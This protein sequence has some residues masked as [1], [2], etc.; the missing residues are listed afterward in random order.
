M[1][2]NFDVLFHADFWAEDAGVF[3]QQALSSPGWSN[4]FEPYAG[5]LHFIPRL[6]A[7]VARALPLLWVPTFLNGSAL[8]FQSL[9]AAL[10]L[11][12]RHAFFRERSSQKVAAL[13]FVLLPASEEVMGSIT[14][15]N[16]FVPF[17]L[18]PLLFAPPCRKNFHRAVDWV[19]F[20]AL[21]L[22]GPWSLFFF[23]LYVLAL[24]RWREW[25]DRGKLA[26]LGL[27]FAAQ[28]AF[29]LQSSRIH[30]G[31]FPCSISGIFR[32]LGQKTFFFTLFGQAGAD[33]FPWD[34]PA[35]RSAAF[36]AGLGLLLLLFLSA[37]RDGKS[38]VTFLISVF[39]LS[40]LSLA[41][42]SNAA[43]TLNVQNGNRYF[44]LG[45]FLTML[46]LAQHFLRS[47]PGLRFAL[48]AG[49]L[50]LSALCAVPLDFANPRQSRYPMP[51]WP[52]RLESL[53]D[54]AAPGTVVTLPIR[55]NGAWS[56]RLVKP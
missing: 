51:S 53:Y 50:A 13:L 27:A 55:P 44:Y 20:I 18:T 10:M 3:F 11:S 41:A 5:Y 17:L 38:P 30:E 22:T 48:S 46:Q 28:C 2:R 14:N 9:G 37:R 47:P 4:L 8:L 7:E 25:L 34:A 49:L 52:E 12:P 40:F 45:V 29:L 24:W 42:T 15:I 33:R 19:G 16:W 32:A 36:L 31:F 6:L 1:L 23:P 39:A 21:A 43:C 56:L 26:V 35:L 54:P